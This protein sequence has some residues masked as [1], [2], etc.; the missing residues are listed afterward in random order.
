MEHPVP[1]QEFSKLQFS[2]VKDGP[3]QAVAR[4][5]PN[6]YHYA[7]YLASLTRGNV[8]SIINDTLRFGFSNMAFKPAQVYDIAYVEEPA[9]EASS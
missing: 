1:Y 8:G 7:I 6:I 2:A 4:L 9:N 5:D 3:G